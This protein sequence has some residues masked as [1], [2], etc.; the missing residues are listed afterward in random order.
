MNCDTTSISTP[1]AEPNHQIHDTSL[2]L[3]LQA[4]ISV[5]DLP[6]R[7]TQRLSRSEDNP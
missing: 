5:S 1:M 7:G 4:T 6:G 2:D 3:T